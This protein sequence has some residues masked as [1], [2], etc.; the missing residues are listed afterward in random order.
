MMQPA[1]YHLVDSGGSALGHRPLCHTLFNAF[2][3]AL[4]VAFHRFHGRALKA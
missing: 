3:K 2:A 4:F 1:L